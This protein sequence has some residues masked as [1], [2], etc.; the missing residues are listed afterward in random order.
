VQRGEVYAGRGGPAVSRRSVRRLDA[1]DKHA[2]E[3]GEGDT[4]KERARQN[5]ALE[6]GSVQKEA[7][8]EIKNRKRSH[9]RTVG[10]VRRIHVGDGETLA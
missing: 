1:Y 7:E 8:K 3:Q 9:E 4:R 5:G 6:R 10:K 2:S